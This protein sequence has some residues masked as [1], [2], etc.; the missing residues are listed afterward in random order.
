MKPTRLEIGTDSLWLD[1]QPFYLASGSMH[2]FRVS[3]EGWQRRLDLM[4]DFGLSCVQTYVP[5]NLHEP[6]E[7][8]FC[9]DGMLNLPSFLERCAA[10]GLRVL[11]RP[12][13]FICA[14]WDFGGLPWWLLNKPGMAI[15]CMNPEFIGAVQKYYETLIPLIV[16]YL[17]TK[18]GPI[19]A[20]AVENEYGGAGDDQEYLLWLRNTMAALGVDVPFYTTDGNQIKMMKLG[21]IPGE[22]MG[23]NYRIESAEAIA[24]LRELQPDK[25]ALVGEYWSG[26][27][28]YFGE[29]YRRRN[30]EEVAAGY[31]E[32]LEHGGL[33]NFY[34]FCGGTNFG[35]MNGT[36]VTDSFDPTGRTMFRAITTS[37]DADAPV[38]EDGLPTAKYYACR[39]ELDRFLG[40]PIR[41]EEPPTVC[42]QSLPPVALREC[43]PV[44]DQL[45]V[46]STP[47][48]SVAPLTMEQLNE[49][50]GFV[51][52]STMLPG[53]IQQKAPLQIEGL[54]DRAQIFTNGEYRGVYQRDLPLP[55]LCLSTENG[56]VKL[57]ILVENM[58]RCNTGR[59]LG[60]Q[61]GITGTVYWGNARLYHWTQ[62]AMPMDNLS[63]LRF[64]E[65]AHA[66]PGFFRGTFDAEPG[67]DTHV[68]LPGFAKGC[69]WINGFALGRHWRIGPQRTL[70]LPGGLLKATGNEI[71]VLELHQAPQ[72]PKVDFLNHSILGGEWRNESL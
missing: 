2:Y 56:P 37:Y 67:I 4:K 13:P 21:S 40:K 33:V 23:V 38:S 44:F 58:G 43:A 7:G 17:S 66:C 68:A 10:T 41:S 65:S 55:E 69:V 9:F 62:R 28:C 47:V 42:C 54:H 59:G 3:P 22:W 64:S 1:D 24:H 32:A 15:R 6:R 36:R 63:R 18:G 19:I 53:G 70:Y 45:D 34:M 49:G 46:L 29:A 26:R 8:R 48:A 60:E 25:P 14:E 71:I 50:Y 12:S 27:S 35:F 61:K 20:M 51:L 39:R 30:V 31:R 11:L 72:N 5:W 57:D 52:Y 16:P